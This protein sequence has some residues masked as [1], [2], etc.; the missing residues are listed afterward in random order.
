MKINNETKIG[1]LTIVAIV[2]LFLGFNFLKGKSIFKNGFYLY[3]K[4]PESKGIVGSNPVFI[5]GFQAGTVSE[6]SASKDLKE[7][8]VEIKLNQDY[9]IPDSSLA[10]INS[11]P[12][13]TSSVEITLGKSTKFLSTKDTLITSLTPGFLGM[14]GSQIKPLA[15]QAKNTLQD[16]DSV[17]L[18]INQILDSTGK[19]NLQQIIVNLN[20]ITQGLVTTTHSF[21]EALNFQTGAFAGIVRNFDDFSKNLAANNGKLDSIMTNMQKTTNNLSEADIKGVMDKL[22]GSVDS[23]NLVF[24]KINSTDGTLG[25]IINSKE[26]YNNLN[27]TTNSLRILLDDLRVHPKRYV[28]ISVFGKKDKGNYLVKPLPQDTLSSSTQK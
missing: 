9:N 27:T 17:M 25:A 24:A 21:N 16:F 28:N 19:E 2:F 3:A 8:L 6:V 13:G 22:K 26:L 14:V 12:L 23:L 1:A 7:I 11:N 20:N 15:E 5:N 18:N 10:N 4:F